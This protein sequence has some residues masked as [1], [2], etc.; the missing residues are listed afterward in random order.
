MS[1]KFQTGLLCRLAMRSRCLT[2][3]LTGLL[4]KLTMRSRCLTLFQTGPAIILPDEYKN[5]YQNAL[6]RKLKDWV[7]WR[8]DVN[9][10][11]AQVIMY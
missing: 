8:E 11:L 3:F 10:V 6:K 5:D 9:N 2:L 4:C 1:K 7:E